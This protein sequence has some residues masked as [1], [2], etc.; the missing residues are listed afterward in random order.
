MFQVTKALLYI[1]LVA[2][3]NHIPFYGLLWQ[4]IDLIVLGS[5]FLAVI[6]PNSFG[7]V[8]TFIFLSFH[9]YECTVSN[10]L[11]TQTQ[12]SM[13]KVNAFSNVITGNPA[14]DGN[15]KGGNR[16]I[17]PVIIATAVCCIFIFILLLIVVFCCCRRHRQQPSGYP[18]RRPR[19]SFSTRG[20]SDALP[21]TP[22]NLPLQKPLVVANQYTD[23]QHHVIQA[24]SRGNSL[25]PMVES[26]SIPVVASNDLN[27]ENTLR[28]PLVDPLSDR[29]R[30]M[31]QDSSSER[32]SGTGD[33]RKSRDNLDEV[34]EAGSAAL[35]S[36]MTVVTPMSPPAKDGG[37]ES[38]ISL[39]EFEDTDLTR[40]DYDDLED[41]EE[42]TGCGEAILS[43]SNSIVSS[44]NCSSISGADE[45]RTPLK[46]PPVQE[47]E[48]V[49]SFRTFQPHR[50]LSR[51]FLNENSHNKQPP[52]PPL[53]PGSLKKRASAI[54]LNG[55]KYLVIERGQEESPKSQPLDPLAYR[56][57]ASKSSNPLNR[58][59]EVNEKLLEYSL[60]STDYSLHESKLVRNP[61]TGG[62]HSLVNSLPRS[63][64]NRHHNRRA[65]NSRRLSQKSPMTS[66]T[67]ASLASNTSTSRKDPEELY[68]T[69]GFKDDK[70]F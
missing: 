6:D 69:V 47:D 30:V 34:D 20:K 56:G 43:A 41:D 26:K 39:T 32:D 45:F 28:L 46:S 3:L 49:V 58:G 67:A 10:P 24:R 5:S 9:R 57:G 15:P 25:I 22:D 68:T 29:L 17:M 27:E 40:L 33:S 60:N 63:R 19:G 23:H 65:S 12:S 53:I 50:S 48:S 13:L 2:Y 38:T 66:K 70:L 44:E 37:G 64:H 18:D 54:E 31:Q 59:L 61:N 14:K 16:D 21:L 8:L 42:E 51:D 62:G 11:G 1:F 35:T 52:L 7:L 4:N 36:S 55:E